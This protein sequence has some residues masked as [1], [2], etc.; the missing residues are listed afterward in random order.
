[1]R[2]VLLAFLFVAVPLAAV[3]GQS[4]ADPQKL[5]AITA[6][7]QGFVESGELS[8]AVTLV[9]RKGGVV[10]HEAVGLRDLAAKAPM[11][12]DSLFRIASMTKPITAVALMILV[13]E[14]KLSPDDDVATHLPEFAGQMMVGEKAEGTLALKRPARP[15]KVR[16]LLTHTGGLANYPPA[17]A[18]TYTKRNHTLAETTIAAGLQPLQFEPGSKW[19][20][21]NPGIDALGR[22]VEVKSGKTYEAFLKERIFDPLGMADTTPYPSA[23]QLKRLA[24]TYKRV[25]D[26]PLTPDMMTVLGLPEAGA[27][28]PVPAGGLYSTAADLARFYRMMLNG[29]ELDGKRV[30]SEKAAAEMTKLQTGDIKTGFTDGMGYG[31]GFGHLREPQG[32]TEALSPGSFGHGGAFG[33]QSWADPKRD[34]ILI[35]LIQRTGLGNSDGSAIRKAF[36]D[37]AAG[38]VRK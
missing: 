10:Y 30:L 8:G 26:G 9:G 25:K 7:M 18:D 33:T 36:Q 34:L 12:R 24:V 4:P 5:A 19:S 28:N 2:R 21:S 6:R 22:I 29:G 11:A 15:V 20:Y 13:D 17:L 27:K 3:R 35:M 32:I 23:E 14:G 16:D 31:F 1:M 37:V 38:A